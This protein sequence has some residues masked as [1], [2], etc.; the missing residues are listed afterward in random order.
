MGADR[1]AFAGATDREGEGGEAGFVH[2]DGEPGGRTAM[3]VEHA[4]LHGIS[5]SVARGAGYGVH[6]ASSTSTRR[7]ADSKS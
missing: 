5:S 4:A 1:E 6:G 2:R 3:H 7:K